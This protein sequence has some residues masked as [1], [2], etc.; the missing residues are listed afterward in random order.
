MQ[1]VTIIC[2]PRDR[3][4]VTERWLDTLFATTPG[5]GTHHP[6]IFVAGGAP[7]VLRERW[8]DRYGDRVEFVLEDELLN[9][10]QVRNIGLAKAETELAVVA[11][12]DCYPRPGWLEAMVARSEETGAAMVSPL[13]LE[14][15]T[16]IHCA[17][18]DLYKNVRDGKTYG[19]KHLRFYRMPYHDGCELPPSRIDYGELHLE[20]VR[21]RPTVEL[22]A[23]DERITEVGEVDSG[24]TWAAGGH[25][26][27]FEPSAVVHFDLGG[28]IDQHDVELF[29]WR[30]DFGNVADGYRVFKDKW[31]FDIAEEG[32]FDKFMV[33]Y[34]ATLGRLA[35]RHPSP[36]TVQ[37]GVRSKHLS[38]RLVKLPVRAQRG[39]RTRWQGMNGKRL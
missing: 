17:G 4:S 10:P 36:L 8:V 35:R 31:G 7:A 15:P 2:G 39:F 16:S 9:Q 20:L 14:K 29:D 19:H 37:L 3:F 13:I 38:D 27:W 21:V 28:H 32:S 12:N 5:A 24:L 34:N 23:F 1:S 25:D 22:G 18:T 6:V 26:M 33:E 30:W 11:D